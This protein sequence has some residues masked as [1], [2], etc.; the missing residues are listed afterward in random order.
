MIACN[1]VF[2]GITIAILT[3]ALAVSIVS[4][5]SVA[6]IGAGVDGWFLRA[7]WGAGAGAFYGAIL[8]GVP[9]I[10]VMTL[11]RAKNAPWR[12]APLVLLGTT[13]GL[14]VAF[15]ATD[16]LQPLANRFYLILTFVIGGPTIG[17]IIA[18]LFLPRRVST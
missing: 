17:G 13:A 6:T 18:S 7:V 10:A 8:G 12:S 11:S 4:A 1:R 16:A 3:G 2:A 5:N 9:G 15:F 14:L